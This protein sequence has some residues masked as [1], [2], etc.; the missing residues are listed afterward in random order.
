M[1]YLTLLLVFL[2][3]VAGWGGDFETSTTYPDG[4]RIECSVK[5]GIGG[6]WYRPAKWQLK[7]GAGIV[8]L[9]ILNHGECRDGAVKCKIRLS[10]NAQ[11]ETDD[12]R[13]RMETAMRAMDAIIEDLDK[14][15]VVRETMRFNTRTHEKAYN[16]WQAVK[17]ACWRGP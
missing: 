13:D 6:C 15:G 12:C 3:P 14:N 17:Q 5:S 1:I 4:S 7:D 10:A 9:E 11:L 8:V 16:Q 2:L